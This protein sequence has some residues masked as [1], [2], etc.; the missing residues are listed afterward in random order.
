MTTDLGRSF[1]P[2]GR[3]RPG[4]AP[5]A[6]PAWRWLLGW[7]AA[8]WPAGPA[9]RS[10]GL[11]V[12]WTGWSS[13]WRQRVSW[14]SNHR[15]GRESIEKQRNVICVFVCLGSFYWRQDHLVLTTWNEKF[16]VGKTLCHF[17]WKPYLEC[18]KVKLCQLLR[19]KLSQCMP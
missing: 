11:D 9:L 4:V 5:T 2:W 17:I 18:S 19:R 7:R 13:H 8:C 16:T 1:W 12:F 6:C 3:R 15:T 14:G 10:A